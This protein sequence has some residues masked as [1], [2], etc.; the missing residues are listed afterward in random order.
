MR[1]ILSNSDPKIGEIFEV[2]ERHASDPYEWVDTLRVAL[3][4]AESVASSSEYGEWSFNREV[5][6]EAV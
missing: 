1:L 3:R 4:W 5:S 2:L 6:H